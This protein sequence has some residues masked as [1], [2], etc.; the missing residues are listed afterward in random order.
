M[1]R[2]PETPNFDTSARP[3]NPEPLIEILEN[4]APPPLHAAAWATCMSKGWHF[5][6]GSNEGGW[7]RF[8]KMDL[9]DDEAFRAI[10]EQA[11]PRC[12]E[13][14]G[15]PLRVIRQ[16]ANG[17]TYG[18][19]G[20]PHADDVK[21][22][23][24]TLLYYPN[25]EWKDGWEGETMY[26]DADGEIA[27][28]VRPKPNRGV[29]F[30]SRILHNGRA[31]S[32]TCPALRVTV[33]YKLEIVPGGRKTATESGAPRD[34][35]RQTDPAPM[36]EL[37]EIARTGAAGRVYYARVEGAAID[38]AVDVRLRK[39]GETVRL[40]G[41]RVGNIPREVLLERYGKQARAETLRQFGATLV[42]KALASGNVPSTCELTGGGEGGDMEVRIQAI[43]MADLPVPDISDRVIE[44]LRLAGNDDPPA[45]AAALLRDR[46][47]E[48]L[49]SVLDEACRFPVLPSLAE[50]E[51]SRV[52]AA[53]EQQSPL[54]QAG[55]DREAALAECREIAERRLR[56]GLVIEEL[57]RRFDIGLADAGS[58]GALE[59][60]VLDRL[61]R[62]ARVEEREITAEE[63]SAL[64]E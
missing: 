10:W 19:G 56:L 38:A 49:L 30:D 26:Y 50:R 25:P 7:S 32:R 27:F 17:H 55:A 31:P 39:L 24:F 23:T 61:M 46:V 1:H 35:A 3:A 36:G 43:A 9:E 44:R 16:Y 5:G 34:M 54:P 22:G 8:W 57:A 59:D 18:L 4:V 42:E 29:F 2:S 33:A 48:Q 63:L 20:E 62:Q 21:P 47:K 14:A 64:M 41:F 60:K 6:H 28:A 51:M 37:R 15:A 45:E 40:P 52:V 58:P 12:E 53:L 13:L 11:R